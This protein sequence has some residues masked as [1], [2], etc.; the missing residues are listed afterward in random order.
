MF[1]QKRDKLTSL[2]IP[3]TQVEN[4]PV[5]AATV[6]NILEVEVGVEGKF[7]VSFVKNESECHFREFKL[8]SR[9]DRD[10][11]TAVCSV[12][13]VLCTRIGGKRGRIDHFLPSTF[14][15]CKGIGLTLEE[16]LNSC[17]YGNKAWR[18]SDPEGLSSNSW[19]TMVEER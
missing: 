5:I 2:F 9:I 11:I 17:L 14:K 6:R 19:L 4:S 3:G 18:N 7:N 1:W 16:S 12:Y 8:K 10:V 13:K 15:G